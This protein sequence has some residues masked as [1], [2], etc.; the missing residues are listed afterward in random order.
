MKPSKK[1]SAVELNAFRAA[2]EHIYGVSGSKPTNESESS[3]NKKRAKIKGVDDDGQPI[4]RNLRQEHVGVRQVDELIGILKGVL[5]DK[6]LVDTEVK[7]LSEW[8]ESNSFASKDWPGSVLHER[9]IRALEDD[10]IDPEELEEIKAI[11]ESIVRGGKENEPAIDLT[12]DLPIDKP[13][14]KIIFKDKIFCF[15]G[16]L[17]WGKRQDAEEAVI[18]K[19]GEISKINKSLNYLVLGEISSRD[20]K[21]STHGLKILKAVQHK[22][23]GV[24]ISIISEKDW[25]EALRI[26]LI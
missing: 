16:K 7:F 8:L 20:W 19:G 5:S 13:T 15:T 2:M 21:H 3:D 1:M 4:N 17:I 11:I 18:N 6:L 10:N 9:I 23:N 12:T 22:E 26:N 14:P 24:N 25:A